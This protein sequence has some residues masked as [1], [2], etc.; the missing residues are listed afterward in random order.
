MR[1]YYGYD[2]ARTEH[3]TGS[4]LAALDVSLNYTNA[5]KQA[6]VLIEYTRRPVQSP[7]AG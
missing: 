7:S 6:C 5:A 2:L 3:V 4:G 1:Y